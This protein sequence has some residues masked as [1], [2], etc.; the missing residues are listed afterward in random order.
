MENEKPFH[1]QC[2]HCQRFIQGPHT[3]EN[4]GQQIAYVDDATGDMTSMEEARAQNMP[5]DKPNV[6]HHSCPDCMPDVLARWRQ[7]YEETKRK[8]AA[9]GNVTGEQEG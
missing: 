1:V 7:D 8:R 4:P 9:S 6:S 3:G 5:I 2:Y